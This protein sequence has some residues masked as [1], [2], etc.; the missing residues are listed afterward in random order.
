[1]VRVVD[2]VRGTGQGYALTPEGV[3]IASG[4]KPAAPE[5][6]AAPSQ[7]VAVPEQPPVVTPALVYA[8][9]LW[10]F[11]GMVIV[12]RQGHSL[13][14]Y[15]LQGE[16]PILIRLGA[17]AAPEFLQGEWWRLATSC[18]VHANIWH[19]LLN[20]VNLV[21]LG[22]I[23][24][25]LWGR[26]RTFILYLVTGFAGSCLA[27]TLRP[28]DA[29]GTMLVHLG[30]SGALCGFFAA[31][32]AWVAFHPRTV[33]GGVT[34]VL[35]RRLGIGVVMVVGVSLLPG[36]SWAAHLGG[37]IAGFA[38]SL[39]L[40]AM[41]TGRGWRRVAGIVLLA[42]LPAACL[43]GL[44]LA[45]RHGEA[46]APFRSPPVILLPDPGPHLKV[47][48][49]ESVTHGVVDATALLAISPAKWKPERVKEIRDHVVALRNNAATASQLLERNTG[50]AATD[51]NRAKAK[52]FADARRAALD[53]LL[54]LIDAKQ[55]PAPD[56][57]K[58]WGRLHHDA[59]RLWGE[60]AAP[61]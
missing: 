4:R 53:K 43:G 32:L 23:V 39:M 52:A 25:H 47:V 34:P 60:L 29:H 56:A 3:M 1:L 58:E 22:A 2:W 16:R 38:A 44:L 12:S 26:G 10:Y 28:M 14:D 30:A 59:N 20:V 11:V 41:H 27:L 57:W 61:P 37:A 46:W 50:D 55:T 19:L 35:V 31:I 33:A 36:I 6:A 13:K 42:M 15:L 49:P 24:E 17:A 9:L 21:A 7:S 18:F 45:T 5:P 40:E 51:A 48:S 54:E 8:N